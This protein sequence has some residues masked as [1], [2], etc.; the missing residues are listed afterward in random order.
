MLSDSIFLI[1]FKNNHYQIQIIN[2]Y[3]I[4]LYSESP[5]ASLAIFALSII[6]LRCGSVITMHYHHLDFELY[7]IIVHI[8]HLCNP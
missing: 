8:F 1:S 2:Q 4:W 6:V 3:Q 5:V 7:D